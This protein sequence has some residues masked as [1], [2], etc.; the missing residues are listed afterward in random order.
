MRNISVSDRFTFDDA[1]DRRKRPAWETLLAVFVC[2]C[3]AA[4]YY[5]GV[6]SLPRGRMRW[7]ELLAQNAAIESTRFVTLILL[8]VESIV[9]VSVRVADPF[10]RLKFQSHIFRI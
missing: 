2:G 4:R 6:I 8:A 1:S 7:L 5:A 9:T 10:Q 3:S